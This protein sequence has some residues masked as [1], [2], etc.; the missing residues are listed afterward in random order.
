M[1]TNQGFLICEYLSDYK[2]FDSLLRSG[3]VSAGQESVAIQVAQLLGRYHGCCV[4]NAQYNTP[5][6]RERFSNEEHV[7]FFKSNF[8]AP[9][10]V[11]LFFGLRVRGVHLLRKV[12]SSNSPIITQSPPPHS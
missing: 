2:S 10:R 3:Q 12:G 9:V 7:A 11:R 1:P 4:D 6:Y 5:E 8:V